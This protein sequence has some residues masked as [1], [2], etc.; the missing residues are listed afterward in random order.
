MRD[1]IKHSVLL[2]QLATNN[3]AIFS[4]SYALNKLKVIDRKIDDLDIILP[5]F[6]DLSHLGEVTSSYENYIEKTYSLILKETGIKVDVMIENKRRYII[7][8][9]IKISNKEPILL[10][11][12]EALLYFGT[13]K[14]KVDL[15]KFLNEGNKVELPI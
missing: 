5:Y 14:H 12:F 1:E 11:K 4:G 9:G 8:D 2:L 10:K 3:L 6:V 15:L 13:E 7:I